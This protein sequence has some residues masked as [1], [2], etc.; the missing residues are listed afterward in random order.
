MND[1]FLMI[2]NNFFIPSEKT[3]HTIFKRIGHEGFTLYTYFQLQTKKDNRARTTLKIIHNDFKN[4]KG[5]KDIRTL[6]RFILNL[7]TNKFIKC[8]ELSENTKA[9]DVLVISVR[10]PKYKNGFS[11]ISN[12]LFLNEVETINTLGFGLYCLLFK[13][14][15][16]TYG[17]GVQGGFA[18]CTEEYMSLIL[19]TGI[20]QVKKTLKILEQ[21]KL[22][23]II[24]Q[25]PNTTIDKYGNQI[26]QYF[27]NHYIVY[28][29][30]Y[31]DN[32]YFIHKS[33]KE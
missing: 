13:N 29:K 18:S 15:N 21:R 4:V 32:K 10:K 27:P 9:N 12:N 33:N 5:F 22:I 31:P 30:I 25:K 8:E 14:H 1:N 24:H 26:I 16:T 6:K 28:A 19:D 23:Q 3:G 2:D 20:T 17:D 7:K 11:M